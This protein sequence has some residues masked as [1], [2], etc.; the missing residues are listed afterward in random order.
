MA[1]GARIS[2]QSHSPSS[3]LAAFSDCR[4]AFG[5]QLGNLALWGVAALGATA[6]FVGHRHNEERVVFKPLGVPTVGMRQ[7]K[8]GMRE[9]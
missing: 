7:A 5:D 6:P 8:Y 9:V 2:S 1:P 4:R 3:E